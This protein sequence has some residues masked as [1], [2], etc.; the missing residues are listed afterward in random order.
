MGRTLLLGCL[1]AA[2]GAC[3]LLPWREAHALGPIDLEAGGRIGGATSPSGAFNPLGFGLGGRAGVSFANIYTGVS[4][5]YYFGE[6]VRTYCCS[7]FSQNVFLLG[8]EGGYN[9]VVLNRVTLRPEIAVG[10]AGVYTT[11]RESPVGNPSYVY[12]SSNTYFY[13]EPGIACVLSLGPVFV[14][15]DVNLFSLPNVRS[16]PNLS[17]AADGEVGVMF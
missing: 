17:F 9:F 7:S 15:T 6:G 4:V 3:A 5:M 11:N 10:A 12:G 8:I 2:V 13:L 14:G 1:A 16:F